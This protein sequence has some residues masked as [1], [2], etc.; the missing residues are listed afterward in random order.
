MFVCARFKYLSSLWLNQDNY[1]DRILIN[2][3]VLLCKV[4][5]LLRT[6][7]RV[8]KYWVKQRDLVTYLY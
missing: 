8:M 7:I 4:W 5:G 3:W 1:I 6:L 2:R